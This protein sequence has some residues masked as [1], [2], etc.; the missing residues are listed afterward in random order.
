MEALRAL[1]R[2]W[3]RQGT[4]TWPL[5]LR[6]D[7]FELAVLGGPLD[8]ESAAMM[9][10]AAARSGDTAH[11]ES[12]LA[13]ADSRFWRLLDIGVR[14]VVSFQ[15]IRERLLSTEVS[16]LDLVIAACWNDG[17]V[18]ELALAELCAVDSPLA[19][20]VLA[21][22]A[23]D[24][25]PEICERAQVICAERLAVDPVTALAGLG[26]VAFAL[27]NRVAGSWLVSVVDSALVDGRV[28]LA[29]MGNPSRRVRR[30]A[31]LKGIAEDRLDIA[32]LSDAALRDP[33]QS[34]RRLCAEAAARLARLS[35][36]VDAV[37]VLLNSRSA[38]VRAEA[39]YTL[40]EVDVA[41]DALC[42][43]SGAVRQVAQVLVRRAELDPAEHY[44]RLLPDPWAVAGLGETGT[45]ADVD[46]LLRCL[47]DLRVRTRAEAVRA[48]RRLGHADTK[49]F[50]P[51]L[52]D[53]APG[54]VKQATT[55]L[56]GKSLPEEFL[57]G[58]I[59][60][61][62]ARVVR[63]AGHRLLRGSGVA[64]RL[65]AD[66]ELLGDP[67]LGGAARE[68]LLNWLAREAASAYPSPT[69]A[70]VG[71]LRELTAAAEAELGPGV[72]RELRFHLDM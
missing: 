65:I 19:G 1:V 66:L 63:L 12:V 49:T 26:P 53:P 64:P 70:Q 48:L 23:A 33:D 2:K 39:I 40:G 25:V 47:K 37:R 54:V 6:E 57:F 59:E 27:E 42:D 72:V 69:P 8:G 34:N 22:R 38:V 58:L 7:V 55:S 3:P 17:H 62:R 14:R 4:I 35:G 9:V 61:G 56:Q 16:R 29:A 71:R 10:L 60:P 52:D 68:D 51:L 46:N 13:K 24:W 31:Y 41:V 18:R 44:R 30:A 50:V 5:P 28:L 67:E 15:V 36:E 20:P 43:R 21:L 32:T 11:A 45:A